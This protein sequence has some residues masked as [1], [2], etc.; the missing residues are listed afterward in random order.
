MGWLITL[1]VLTGLAIC[2]VGVGI[3]YNQDGPRLWLKAAFLRFLL[4]PRKKKP[5]TGEPKKKKKKD[6]KAVQK[7]NDKKEKKKDESKKGGKLTDFLP[8]VQIGLDFL[9]DFRR[10]LRVNRLELK[11]ILAGGDPCDLA[12]NY[13]KAWTAVGNLMPQLERFLV[14]RKRNVEVECDFMEDATTVYARVDVTITVGRILAITIWH[15][16]RAVREYLKIQKIR[17]GGALK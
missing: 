6:D 4:Y 17:K 7:P 13:G 5:E 3:L 12:V 10:K 14:I 16:I 15:G 9:S 1:L 11:I 8:L 2:P